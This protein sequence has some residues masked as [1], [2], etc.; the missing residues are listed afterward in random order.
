MRLSNLIISLGVICILFGLTT[1]TV[2]A[3]KDCTNAE[4][5]TIQDHANDS[6]EYLGTFFYSGA[7]K[8]GGQLDAAVVGFK[9]GSFVTCKI[10]E[11]SLSINTEAEGLNEWGGRV[12]VTI[13]TNR[14]SGL[15]DSYASNGW[16]PSYGNGSGPQVALVL[17]IDPIN[18]AAVKAGT[19]V[20]SQTA[21]GLTN[22]AIVNGVQ[23]YDFKV[24]ITGV[25]SSYVF[26]TD[27]SILNYVD[28][29][30]GSEFHYTLDY[31]MTQL[32][33]VECNG[34]TSLSEGVLRNTG[35]LPENLPEPINSGGGIFAYCNETGGL[36]I[37]GANNGVGYELFG[38]PNYTIGN[39]L[40]LAVE[41]G[42]HIKLG[43]AGIVSLWALSTDE[44]Q[45]HTSEPYN[46]IFSKYA[47][48]DPVVTDDPIT[49]ATSSINPLL[50]DPESPTEVNL[51]PE[52]AASLP[53]YN[54]SPISLNADGT[55]TVKSGDTLALIATRMGVDVAT[56]AEINRIVDTGYIVVGQILKIP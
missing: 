30:R 22:T 54:P 14:G 35:E 39:G 53:V 7:F 34:V 56:L 32:L 5:K 40:K 55:Y 10:F 48:G 51:I 24:H 19:Y 4:A 50:V 25:A 16:I 17:E 28:C 21:E 29:P 42:E 13:T 18:D 44:L 37:Y 26:N 6:V 43:E 20:I 8:R 2:L 3:K 38:V 36:D 45:L 31:D 27:G 12:F 41:T 52:A 11:T 23:F 47:C 15:L 49:V 9:R 1:Q 33:D 46:F